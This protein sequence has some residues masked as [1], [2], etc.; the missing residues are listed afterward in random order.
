MKFPYA[1][2]ENKI[3][4]A[5]QN[6]DLLKTAFTH[7][8]HANTFGGEDNERL[9]YLGDAVLQL[10]VTEWQYER[11]RQADEGTMTR[12][13]QKLVCE[14]ALLDAVRDLEIEQY[15][16]IAGSRANVGKKTVSSLFETVTAA[17]YLDGGYA[18]AKAFILK[19]G[20]DHVQAQSENAKGELQEYLQD[21][22]ENP[23]R[24]ETEKVGKD[25]DPIF[26]AKVFALGRTEM[27]E[28]KSKK[29]AEQAAAANLLRELKKNK[30]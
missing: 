7:S 12:V 20:L 25:N 2:I 9:E 6:R 28:G 24:Y 22:G 23:P 27:G 13:R 30:R 8:T 3:G 10:V 11:Y 18:A 26:Y 19:H 15:L 21:I 1:E 16:L 17:I 29:Q 14:E 5:F 4:Y